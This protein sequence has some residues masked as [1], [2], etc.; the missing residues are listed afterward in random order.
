M[1]RRYICTDTITGILSAVYDAWKQDRSDSEGGIV[2]WGS[3][4][5]EMFCRYYEVR[6]DEKKV[7]AVQKLI[8]KYMGEEAYLA[9]GQALLSDDEEKGTAI[10]RTMIEARKLSNAGT[11]MGHLKHP[12]V[13]KVFELSRNVSRETHAWKEFLRFR[14]LKRGILF[15]KITP[16]NAILPGIAGHFS[17]RFPMED[18]IIY[19]E[20]HSSF[21]IHPKRRQ[22]LIIT[23][24]EKKWQIPEEYSDKEGGWQRLW[25]V[26]K[27]SV[28]IQERE[29][30]KLQQ[31]NMPLRYRNDMTEFSLE[32]EING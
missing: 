5:Q 11:I 26:F 10:L 16:R 6:E 25:K 4:Q 2:F 15:A 8:W 17:D 30:R 32:K 9:I 21:L 20:T 28:T 22:W 7:H 29:N 27:E 18:F 31:T 14:E 23:D 12:A 1:K 24:E 19:D 3:V 13:R